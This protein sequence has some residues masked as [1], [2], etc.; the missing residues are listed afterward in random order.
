[1]KLLDSEEEF[2]CTK[3]ELSSFKLT[4]PFGKS[5]MVGARLASNGLIF[6]G[7]PPVDIQLITLLLLSTISELGIRAKT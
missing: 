3:T 5:V 4:F 2:F 7:S 1:M 6:S